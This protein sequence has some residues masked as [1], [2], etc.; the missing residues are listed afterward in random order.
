[1]ERLCSRGVGLSSRPSDRLESGEPVHCLHG[2]VT[3]HLVGRLQAAAERWTFRATEEAAAQ[4]CVK[5]DAGH[6]GGLAGGHARD[7]ARDGRGDAAG[8]AIRATCEAGRR[9]GK[10]IRHGRIVRAVAHLG[11]AA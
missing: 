4:V 5:L 6:A 1:M 11:R 3:T 2:G 10:G 9:G 7:R 8:A